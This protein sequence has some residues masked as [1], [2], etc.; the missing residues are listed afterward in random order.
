MNHPTPSPVQGPL[1]SQP[2]PAARLARILVSAADALYD[3]ATLEDA[4]E[5]WELARLAASRVL[6]CCQAD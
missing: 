6:A 3:A 1:V 5:M 4:G 2:E